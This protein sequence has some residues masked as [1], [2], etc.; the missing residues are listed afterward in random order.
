MK[1]LILVRHGQTEANLNR[2]LQGQS[3]GALT[4]KGEQQAEELALHL[5]DM[6][7]DRILSSDLR[8]AED[9]A[10]ALAKHHDIKPITMHI[11]REWNCGKLDLL[12]A[13]ALK[14]ALDQSNQPLPDFRPE[15]GETLREVRQRAAA[16]LQDVQSRYEELNVLV[17]SHGDFIRMLMS[18]LMQ[19]EIEEAN[20]IHLDNGS[21]SVFD[22][23]GNIWSVSAINKV[24]HK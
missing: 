1:R 6:A 12:P 19:I 3:N 22:Q 16:F 23:D 5:K 7:I 14:D 10:A 24:I 4:S 8:R 15:G 9:T 18:L 2:R 11:L 17:C 20:T 21:Y 13:E